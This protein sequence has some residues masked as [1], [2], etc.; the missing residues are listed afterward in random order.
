M[1]TE[2]YQ[3]V[4][5]EREEWRAA[6]GWEGLYEV[7][8]FGRVRSLGRMANRMGRWG[9]PSPIPV[10]GRVLRVAVNRCGYPV[11]GLRNDG[12]RQVCTIHRLVAAA[13]IGPSEMEIRHR[14]GNRMNCHVSNLAYSTH[15]DNMADMVAHGTCPL[16]AKNPQAKLT[17]EDIPAI[18]NRLASG[19]PKCRIGA[20]FGVSEATIRLIANGRTWRHV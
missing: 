1:P 19:V 14:D 10:R 20:E 17:E 5:G 3:D 2:A 12:N 8:D 18:R 11:V 4:P 9:T 13:F 16:G 7:S 6:P 15:R